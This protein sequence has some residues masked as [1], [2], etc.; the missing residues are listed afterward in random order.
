MQYSKE[1]KQQ[2]LEHWRK[3]G[4]SQS[5]YCR[6]NNLKLATFHYWK[7]Q[8]DKGVKSTVTPFIPT[9][10]KASSGMITVNTPGGLSISCQLHQ[11][12][13]VLQ[14]LQTC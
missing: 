8:A 14:A 1:D 5:A 9:T 2:H 13:H 4:L 7:I 3:S 12:P 6:E 11:L 10:V